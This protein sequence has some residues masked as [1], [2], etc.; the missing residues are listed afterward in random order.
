MDTRPPELRVAP[1]QPA[2]DGHFAGSLT[3]DLKGELRFWVSLSV[4]ALAIAGALALL[5]AFSRVPGADAIMPWDPQSLFEKGLV[6]H[7]TFAFVVWYVG[8]QAA[9]TV[10]VSGPL[11]T[12][13]PWQVWIGKAGAGLGLASFVLLLIPVLL[14]LG[15]ASLNNYVPVIIHPFFYIGLAVLALGVMCTIA[16]LMINM[17]NSR[18]VEPLTFAISC[19]GAI[20]ILAVGCIMIAWST[21]PEDMHPETWNE[22]LFWGGG[23]VLQFANTALLI[24]A[25][26]GLTRVALGE[27]PLSGRLWTVVFLALVAGAACGPL[28]YFI[29]PT[30]SPAET[31]AFTSL[32]WWVLA[33]PSAIPLLAVTWMLA[34]DRRLMTHVPELTG[35]GVMLLLFGV[36]GAFGYFESSTDTRTPAHYHAMLIAVTLTFMMFFFAV[37]VP[38]LSKRTSRPKV[39]VLIYTLLGFGQLIHSTGLFMAGWLGVA[40]KTAGAEQGLDTLGKVL[41]MGLMGTGGLIAVIGGVMFVVSAI[42]CLRRPVDDAGQ[43]VYSQHSPT[44]SAVLAE[45]K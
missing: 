21:M 4:A 37:L 26:G 2:V 15:D 24:A 42:K 41:S 5:L 9:L 22:R 6:A 25:V 18:H 17:V 39:R 11:M 40:R 36:G 28:I 8:L 20:F 23:H 30:A 16:R 38:A 12:D 45:A 31:T 10:F 3:D 19:A 7:V 35:L 14:D 33:I 32:Y 34:R 29:H 27:M 43:S 13:S 44:P 1:P